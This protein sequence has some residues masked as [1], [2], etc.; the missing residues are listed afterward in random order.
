[1][2]FYMI[3]QS[4][5]LTRSTLWSRRDLKGADV[6]LIFSTWFVFC[7]PYLRLVRPICYCILLSSSAHFSVQAEKLVDKFK[8]MWNNICQRGYNPYTSHIM[9]PHGSRSHFGLSIN[10]KATFTAFRLYRKLKRNWPK[11]ENQSDPRLDWFMFH[12]IYY[13]Y[14]DNKNK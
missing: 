7:P 10:E 2:A 9:T 13:M 4:T 11:R 3:M 14:S 1:M 8:Y 5:Y 6:A 12:K